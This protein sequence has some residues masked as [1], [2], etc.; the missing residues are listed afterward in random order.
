MNLYT[1]TVALCCKYLV[2]KFRKF[3]LPTLMF[4]IRM[5]GTDFG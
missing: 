2:F 4:E 5:F 1:E 3:Q